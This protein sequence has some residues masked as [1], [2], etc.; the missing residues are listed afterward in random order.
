[1]NYQRLIYCGAEE[2]LKKIQVQVKSENFHL[3]GPT[4]SHLPE[5]MRPRIVTGLRRYYINIY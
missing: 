5:K 3:M 2:I 4:V 1:M